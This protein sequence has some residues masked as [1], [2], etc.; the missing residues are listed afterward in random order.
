M[1]NNMFA[2]GVL[3][4]VFSVITASGVVVRDPQGCI[5]LLLRQLIVVQ[6]GEIS[7]S[8]DFLLS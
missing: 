5:R 1:F 7:E 2:L 8:G 4:N 6:D 3:H